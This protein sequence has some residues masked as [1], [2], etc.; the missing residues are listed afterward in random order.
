MLERR[1]LDLSESGCSNLFFSPEI[2]KILQSESIFGSV[3]LIG[4]FMVESE[5]KCTFDLL[6]FQMHL[7]LVSDQAAANYLPVVCF[8]PKCVVLVVSPQM[9]EQAASLEE[10]LKR[11]VPG[12]HVEHL[13]IADTNDINGNVL[14]FW[15]VLSEKADLKPLVNL[16]GGTKTMS[17]AAMKA[18]ESEGCPAFYLAMENNSITFFP[19]G[20]LSEERHIEHIGFKPK[21]Q[22]YLAAYG[23]LS[24]GVCPKS[25]LLSDSELELYRELIVRPEFHL[26]IPLINKF[27]VQAEGRN[28]TRGLKAALDSDNLNK[29]TVLS[30][31][32]EFQRAGYLTYENGELIFTG[33]PNRFFV[34]G[35][36]MEKY[37]A[38]CLAKLGMHPWINLEVEKGVKNEI[39]VAFLRNNCLYI[40]ECKTSMTKNKETAEKVVYKLETLK[41][42][43]G[44]KTQLILI[45]YQ[46]VE[47]NA[48][49]RAEQGGIAVIDGKKIENLKYYLRQ[50]IE[51]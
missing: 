12:I 2:C 29:K 6:Q 38:H 14:A 11:A 42:I 8:R 18:A 10:A 44:L 21:I 13:V 15:N 30:A 39:D 40:V 7:C 35:G 28:R 51:S 24:D 48:K 31:V 26:A 20:E 5:N 33:E 1:S 47:K 19:K 49:R 50:V 4:G 25:A 46:D 41:K 23:Y 45:S 37:A 34:A 22:S 17:I 27:V 9:K 3:D 43:G 36:W 32:D 16:T